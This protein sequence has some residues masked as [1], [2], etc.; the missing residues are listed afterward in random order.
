MYVVSEWFFGLF[1]IFFRYIVHLSV[2]QLQLLITMKISVQ[3][4]IKIVP[5]SIFQPVKRKRKT[6]AKKTYY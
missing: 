5:H 2:V 6:N 1:L 3:P 4:V